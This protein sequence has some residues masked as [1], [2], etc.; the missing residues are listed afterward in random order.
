[1]DRRTHPSPLVSVLLLLVL[2]ASLLWRIGMPVMQIEHVL[3]EVVGTSGHEL[4]HGPEL[5]VTHAHADEVIESETLA[6]T[7]HV[8]LHALDTLDTPPAHVARP[9]GPRAVACLAPDLWSH[10]APDP[11]VYTLF[12]PPRTPAIH[13]S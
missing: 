10:H 8:F 3:G 1:M 11:P 9:G 7:V 12:R 2:L 6:H 13:L 5:A 4:L